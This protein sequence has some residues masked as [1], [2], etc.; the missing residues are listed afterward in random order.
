MERQKQSVSSIHDPEY[1]R[2]VDALIS[3]REKAK[4]SQKAIAQEIGLTQPDVSKIERRER[5][6]DVLEALRWVRAT[7]TDPSEFFAQF[8]N[9][10]S[11]T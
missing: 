8:A 11:E 2:I 6:I 4:L 7:G 3:L 9:S 10:E 5:R 1:H